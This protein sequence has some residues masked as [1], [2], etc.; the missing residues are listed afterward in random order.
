MCCLGDLPQTSLGDLRKGTVM[1]R[2]KSLATAF[3]L[4]LA[5]VAASYAEDNPA[6]TRP[7]AVQ[8]LIS[9]SAA[10]WNLRVQ[11]NHPDGVY[12]IGERMTIQVSSPRECYVHI[13]NV[14]PHGEINVL[15]PMD[16]RTSNRVSPGEEVVFPDRGNHPDFVF[17]ATAPVGKELIVCFATKTPL[18]LKSPG[19][20]RMFDEFLDEVS[21]ISP[22][23]LT[24]LRSFV[25]KV[26]PEKTGWTATAFELETRD[27]NAP[28]TPDSGPVLPEAPKVDPCASTMPTVLSEQPKTTLP[29]AEKPNNP[30]E[31]EKAKSTALLTSTTGNVSVC[32]PGTYRTET[33]NVEPVAGLNVKTTVSTYNKPEGLFMFAESVLTTPVEYFDE[34][35]AMNG[36]TASW[37]EQFKASDA[38]I[39]PI[40]HGRLNGCEFVSTAT[41]GITTRLRAFVD[42]ESRASYILACIGSETFV[43]GKETAAF[44]NSLKILR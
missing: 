28:P 26:E 36:I 40:K 30:P 10:E 37:K 42:P 43:N 44:L 4:S 24:R 22:N 17:E 5:S 21:E 6:A 19:D 41:G 15:W 25:T 7:A 13:V 23:P 3:L 32:F 16:S 27:K 9:N 33:P 35:A 29:D 34:Q 39:K 2:F 38:E 31:T 14:N 12:Q 18:N 1:V 11:L 20:A 8:H